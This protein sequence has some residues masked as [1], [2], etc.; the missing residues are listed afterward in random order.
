MR[1]LVAYDGGAASAA[2]L[3]FAA[4]RAELQHA[5]LHLLYVLRGHAVPDWTGEEYNRRDAAESVL[6][7]AE[8]WV[9]QHLPLARITSE[10]RHGDAAEQIVAATTDA[11]LIVVGS[12][13][14]D[15]A[16]DAR[17]ESVPRKV[18]S[19]ARCVTVVVPATWSDRVGPVVVGVGDDEVSGDPVDFAVETAELT[20]S[21]LEIVHGWQP[22]PVPSHIPVGLGVSSARIATTEQHRADLVAERVRT[23]HE[24]LQVRTVSESGRA[25]D[26]VAER[27]ALASLTVVGRRRSGLLAD[28]LMGSVTHDLLLRLPSP[29][30]VVPTLNTPAL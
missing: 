18:A 7:D 5:E 12:K 30:A 6:D 28:W 4:R 9:M 1:I 24:S 25:L 13:R 29:V 21:A 23:R 27:A 10:L 22:L 16:T 17:F 11:D 14:G 20:S 26:L 19:L 8:A 3:T 15:P 2:A